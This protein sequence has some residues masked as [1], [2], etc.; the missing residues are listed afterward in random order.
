MAE[1][2]SFK[3]IEGVGEGF[4]FVRLLEAV[5]WLL[6][7]QTKDSKLAISTRVKN[8]FFGMFTSSFVFGLKK[9][10]MGTSSYTSHSP[11]GTKAAPS[12]F[13]LYR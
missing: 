4:A 13:L 2:A 7:S 6:A 3:G 12:T 1:T 10:P 9:S 11:E 8:T 5:D